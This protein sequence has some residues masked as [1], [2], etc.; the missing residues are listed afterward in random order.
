MKPHLTTLNRFSECLAFLNLSGYTFLGDNKFTVLKLHEVDLSLPYQMP[1]F[2]PDYYNLIVV[3][4]GHG[5]YVVGSESFELT[6]NQIL[7]SSPDSFNSSSWSC[8]DEV[9]YFSFSEDFLLN[10]F[11]S[12]I[13]EI[14]YLDFLKYSKCSLS[15]NEMEYLS[16]TCKDICDIACS[17]LP[18]KEELLTNLMI[19]LLILFQSY[20]SSSQKICNYLNNNKNSILVKSFLQNIEQNF[21]N[22]IQGKAESLMRTKEHA[23]LL[24]MSEPSF[25]KIISKCTG[26]TVNE[27]INQK[28]VDDIIYLLKFSDL[29]MKDISLMFGFSDINYFYSY[30]KLQTLKAPGAVRKDYSLN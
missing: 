6:S 2:R 16:S 30:F 4:N 25:S 18:F 24:N 3:S 1:T 28:L 19:N 23:D 21:R 9:Y 5:N 17:T 27:W 7:L 15:L 11:P 8:I 20:K 12:D 22:L 29:P 10:H 13:D 26:K 14:L